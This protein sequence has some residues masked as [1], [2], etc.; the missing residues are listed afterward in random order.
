MRNIVFIV[1]PMFISLDRDMGPR[2]TTPHIGLA[3]VAAYLREKGYKVSIIDSPIEKLK[4][5]DIEER[6]RK[7]KP[8]F[9]GMTATSM[10]IN[11]AHLLAKF[12]KEEIDRN[13]PIII[14]GYHATALPKETLDYSKYFDYV[15]YGEGEI[16][17]FELLESIEENKSLKNISGIAYRKG[18]KLMVNKPRSRISNLDSLPFPALDL[19]PLGKY[20]PC[21]SLN[22]KILEVPISSSRGCPYQCIF[23]SRPMGKKVVMRSVDNVIEEIKRDVFELGAEQLLFTDE[24]FTLDR[25]RVYELCNRM[26]EEGLNEKMKWCCETRV[27]SVDKKLL[28]KMKEAGCIYLCYG[29]ESGN[30][31]ILKKIKKNTTTEQAK[32][33]IALAKE[34][35]IRVLTT[36]ILGHPYETADTIEQTINFILETDPDFAVFSLLTPF[37]GSEMSK[38]AEHDKGN[39][40]LISKDWTKYGR[41]IGGAIELKN[42]SRKELELLQAKAYMKFYMRPGR[43]LNLFKVASINAFPIYFLHQLKNIFK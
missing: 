8:D 41:Q 31:Y 17:T 36:C 6:I 28:E 14:G 43:I 33:A 32:K 19:F 5:Q 7:I 37:P 11:E 42:L 2:H 12:I 21:A 35:G 24:T 15:V 25:K 34:S 29:I 3:Y 4:L 23:C 38:M 16:T 40:R 10:Q 13:M 30:D 27:D 20:N 26:I 22:K 18:S 39:L 1:P 9:I